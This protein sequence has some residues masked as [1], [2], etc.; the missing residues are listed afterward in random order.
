M[1]TL[2]GI[3]LLSLP[4]DKSTNLLWHLIFRN[5]A[6]E[7]ERRKLISDLEMPIRDEAPTDGA[8]SPEALAADW[9]SA[10]G[11]V[12]PGVSRAQEVTWPDHPDNLPPADMPDDG[13]G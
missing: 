2:E 7:K 11:T 8:W 13:G 1:L 12:L 5:I 10:M 4:L 6:D 9:A 3:D